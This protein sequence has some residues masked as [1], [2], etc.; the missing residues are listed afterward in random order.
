MAEHEHDW[1]KLVQ[2]PLGVDLYCECRHRE[3]VGYDEVIR[4]LN[5]AD[6]LSAEH[7]T[8]AA[9]DVLGFDYDRGPVG[10]DQLPHLGALRAYA[11]AREA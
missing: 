11:A 3:F 2:G 9:S 10:E 7:A 4:R 5:A 1:R 6:K 8:E